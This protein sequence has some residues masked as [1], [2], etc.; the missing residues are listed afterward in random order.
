MKEGWK[1]V[2]ICGEHRIKAPSIAYSGITADN[3]RLLERSPMKTMVNCQT[4][5]TKE[6]IFASLESQC[7]GS[8]RCP[9]NEAA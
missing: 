3:I 6:A 7:H 9:V 5:L 1:Q 2:G 8:M 4:L